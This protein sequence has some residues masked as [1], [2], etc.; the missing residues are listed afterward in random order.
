MRLHRTHH[1][2]GDKEHAK[3]RME[4]SSSIQVGIKL[5]TRCMRQLAPQPASMRVM[6][7]MAAA[8]RKT[9]ISSLQRMPPSYLQVLSLA[10]VG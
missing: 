6:D 10:T 5:P 2:D 1:Y 3:D 9:P 8:G 7:H 4:H